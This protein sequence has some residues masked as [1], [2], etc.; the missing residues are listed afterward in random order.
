M[1]TTANAAHNHSM[2]PPPPHIMH[3]DSIMH[4]FA[5]HTTLCE[6]SF[7]CELIAADKLLLYCTI[8][9]GKFFYYQPG[10]AIKLL[11]LV[12]S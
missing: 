10:H 2:D 6:V 7:T 12:S 9:I 8:K 11:E 5:V 3:A 1:T 4:V